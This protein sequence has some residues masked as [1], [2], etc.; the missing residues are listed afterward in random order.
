MA[1][2]FY[3]SQ[4]QDVLHGFIKNMI[5]IKKCCNNIAGGI[6]FLTLDPSWI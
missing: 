1:A 3:V 5:I 6:H 2:I 4:M